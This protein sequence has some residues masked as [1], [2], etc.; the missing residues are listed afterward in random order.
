[1]PWN[2][3]DGGGGGQGPWG[4]GGGQG[5][6]GNGGGDKNGGDR[7]QNPWGNRGGGN[8]GG[9]SNL[10]PELDDLLQKGKDSLKNA[11]PSGGGRGTWLIPIALFVLYAAYN[12][13][14]QVQPDERGVVLR[15]GAYSRTVDPGLQFA[16]WPVEKI[17]K[18]RVGF[19]DQINIGTAKSEGQ[20]L[21]SDKNIINV[22]FTIQW[23]IGTAKDFLFN[24]AD[25][26]RTISALAQSAMREV[27]AQ[28]NAQGVLTTDKD[29]IALQ[30]MTI[31]QSL[32]DGYQAGVII[33]AVNLGDVQPP[34]EVADAFADVVRADQDKKNLENQAQLTLNQKIQEAAGQVAKLSEDANAYKTRIVAEAEGDASRFLAVYEQYKNAKDVTRQRLFLETMEGVLT[35]ANKVIIESGNGGQGV[36]PYLPLPQIQKPA[37]Q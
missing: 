27:V 17:E 16:I 29:A 24:V 23:Q 31:T 30:V 20:M 7:N 15:L 34:D 22:P 18:L 13:V 36:V 1:M 35:Q 11:L 2:K 9:G 25:Q 33:T 4:G 3:D 8:R 26:E 10:P 12:S 28:K 32:L 37:G 21:T 6:W 14:Y 5:P 19:V